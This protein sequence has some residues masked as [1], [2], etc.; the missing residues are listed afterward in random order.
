MCYAARKTGVTGTIFPR[1]FADCF[2]GSPRNS[3]KSAV[4]EFAGTV[5]QRTGFLLSDNC[6]VVGAA[7]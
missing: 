4:C 1:L 5:K 6:L 7:R 3:F 2:R